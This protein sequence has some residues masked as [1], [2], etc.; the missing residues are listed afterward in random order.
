METYIYLIYCHITCL[1]SYLESGKHWK[2]TDKRGCLRRAFPSTD[3]LSNAKEADLHF[4]SAQ[5]VCG[6]N[7]QRSLTWWAGERELVCVSQTLS[8]SLNRVCGQKT[9]VKVKAYVTAAGGSFPLP[10]PPS[11][12]R[13]V[14]SHLWS[15]DAHT[16]W[17]ED[18]HSRWNLLRRS[19][20]K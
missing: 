12:F 18:W 6:S 4:Y 16:L 17:W 13:K 3:L 9:G 14:S 1:C 7:A 2:I 19:Q 5:L 15:R 20:K 10:L 11:S 8:L